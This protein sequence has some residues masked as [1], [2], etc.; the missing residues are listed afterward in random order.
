MDALGQQGAYTPGGNEIPLRS[1]SGY[2]NPSLQFAVWTTTLRL[3]GCRLT[4][5]SR[6]SNVRDVVGTIDH[7]IMILREFD[8][9]YIIEE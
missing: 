3:G 7:Y 6:T 8:K 4:G 1:V 2:R 5:R 9:R